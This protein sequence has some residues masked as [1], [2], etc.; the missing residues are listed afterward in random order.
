MLASAAV[1]AVLSVAQAFQDECR[2][3][4]T[5]E[6]CFVPGW[7]RCFT[8]NNEGMCLA[9][10][11]KALWCGP[12]SSLLRTLTTSPADTQP[13]Q[14]QNPTVVETNPNGD[15]NIGQVDSGGGDVVIG[16]QCEPR[17]GNVDVA[18][19]PPPPP[20]I[21]ACD[22]S[23]RHLCHW[24]GTDPW[25]DGECRGTAECGS[26][27]CSMSGS[28]RLCCP[29]PPDQVYICNVEVTTTC[30]CGNIQINMNCDNWD[31]RSCSG[32]VSFDEC[33]KYLD[34][35]EA[36]GAGASCDRSTN[37]TTRSANP[38][39]VLLLMG[40][41][42]SLLAWTV[43]GQVGG[44]VNIGVVNTGGGN[45]VNGINCEVTCPDP[46]H[47]RILQV[48]ASSESATSTMCGCG[49]TWYQI[50]CE[51][52]NNNECMMANSQSQES[53]GGDTAAR[54]GS[55]PSLSF[56]NQVTS[57]D[58]G[59]DRALKLFSES[60]EGQTCVNMNKAAICGIGKM[61]L[62][63]LAVKNCFI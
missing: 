13:R 26:D 58:Q 38:T 56:T 39:T 48:T 33:G 24:D 36:A 31:S 25:C 32:R 19:C 53:T 22:P 30:G 57:N 8:S 62:A 54:G 45:V 4:S 35:F 1:L 50:D 14:L 49:N 44:D 55:A 34:A 3:C 10:E 16:T 40:L 17:C 12:P 23:R 47:S 59:C 60:S 37:K 43:V 41:S 51:M 7:S 63:A 52:S 42:V 18:P 61:T 29:Q 28:K 6:N 20:P 46:G 2:N 9:E 27:S 5:S 11:S 21:T 15:T